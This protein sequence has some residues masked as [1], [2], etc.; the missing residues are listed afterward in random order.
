MIRSARARII[1]GTNSKWAEE[2]LM[3]IYEPFH[4]PIVSVS[5]RSAEMSNYAANNFLALKLSYLNDIAN[6]C[7]LVG[8]DI[9]DVARGMSF[10]DRIGSRFLNAGI[11]YGGSCFPK[12]TKALERLAGQYGYK[13]RTVQ[14]AID[15]NADQKTVLFKKASK[16]LITFGG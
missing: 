1:I 8:A 14:A 2:M 4:L 12:D 11:G 16:R 15:V 13:L 5:R 3:K 6:L 7:E 10:D 9:Q